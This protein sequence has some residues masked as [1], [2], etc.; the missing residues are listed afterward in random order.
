MAD[1]QLVAGTD[2]AVVLGNR[3]AIVYPFTCPSWLDLRVGFYLSICSND[4]SSITGLAETLATLGN[5]ADRPWMG[6][7]QNNDI[8]PNTAGTTFM[9]FCSL[10]VPDNPSDSKVL[11]S[12]LDSGTSNA[13]YWRGV[14]VGNLNTFRM[15]NGTSSLNGAGPYYIHMP[16][17]AGAAGGNATLVLM[18][19]TRPSGASTVITMSHWKSG[20]DQSADYLYDSVCSLASM[21]AAFRAATFGAI[22]APTDIAG[23]VPDALFLYW[24]FLNSRLRVHAVCIEKFF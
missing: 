5:P 1:I 17:N 14:D 10:S 2:K 19:F 16:Q 22:F 21:R 8:M 11:S 18:R 24:P 20:V 23:A 9:G 3:E 6:L 12:D 7:K 4:E 15:M 13:N